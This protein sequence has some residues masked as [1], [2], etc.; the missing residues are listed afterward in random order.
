MLFD[1]PDHI[2]GIQNFRLVKQVSRRRGLRFIE[3][4]PNQI[5]AM[6]CTR[7]R[8]IQQAQVFG[9]LFF[10][11]KDFVLVHALGA[12]VER[13]G[14]VI[15]LIVKFQGVRVAYKRTGPGERTKHHRIFQSL[16]HVHGHQLDGILVAFKSELVRFNRRHIGH[17]LFRQPLQEAGHA[18]LLFHRGLM[19]HLRK[20][21]YVGDAAFAI[22]VS[23]ESGQ[24]ILPIQQVFEHAHESV[25]EPEPVIIGKLIEPCLQS[26]FIFREAKQFFSCNAN[27]FGSQGGF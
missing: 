16:A 14:A 12:Q 3:P 10:L 1:G 26:Q 22:R 25:V 19:Q 2:F 7:D 18:E 15:C 11:R 21:Q 24:Q 9:Q 23:H 13:E 5:A 20:M 17:P 27:D 6:F 4:S 8:N